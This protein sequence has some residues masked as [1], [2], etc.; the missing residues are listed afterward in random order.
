MLI[1]IDW[2]CVKLWV[3]STYNSCTK[4]RKPFDR[5]KHQRS[6]VLILTSIDNFKTGNNI[7]NLEVLQTQKLFSLNKN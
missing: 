2:L 3:T 1:V 4:E 6:F 5:Q 7:D